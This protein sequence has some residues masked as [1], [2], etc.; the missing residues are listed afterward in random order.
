MPE[1]LLLGEN[2]SGLYPVCF[3]LIK[4]KILSVFSEVELRILWHLF[5]HVLILVAV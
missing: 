5:L 4:C 1:R 3:T 2:I